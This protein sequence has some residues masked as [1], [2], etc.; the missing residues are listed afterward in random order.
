M[1]K[2]IYS[3]KPPKF[4]VGEVVSYLEYPKKIRNK[5]PIK[6]TGLIMRVKTVYFLKEC[7]TIVQGTHLYN[8][9]TSN[10]WIKEN[11]II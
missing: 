9:K 2:V 4:F 3:L 8:I 7:R 11:D 10:K 5:K 6:K 1:T